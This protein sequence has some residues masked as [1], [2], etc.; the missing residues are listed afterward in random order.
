MRP[1]DN[2]VNGN[3]VDPAVVGLYNMAMA[4]ET[5]TEVT[6]DPNSG[7]VLEQGI[8]KDDWT[9]N[10][11]LSGMDWSLE[12]LSHPTLH[13]VTYQGCRPG[14]ISER[15]AKM[16][17]GRIDLDQVREETPGRLAT[18]ER[19][20]MELKSYWEYTDTSEQI[21]SPT[22]APRD[23]G[24]GT[25]DS[26]E[27]GQAGGHDGYVVQPILSDSGFR[28]D[29]FDAANVG[30]G[31]IATLKGT[32]NEQVPVVLHSAWMP[33]LSGLVDA[34]RLRFADELSDEAMASVPE[35]LHSSIREVAEECD[36][37]L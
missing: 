22:F 34:D 18:F 26:Y 9:F 5:I 20:S 35:E 28:V 11:Q 15:A 4:P 13:H 25:S 19:G 31:P 29:L 3:P 14:N 36:A 16:Y 33:Q 32:N 6:F 30:A 37:L 24:K 12:G 8:Y 10:L 1:D 27:G 7:K 23:A 2:D 21:T 17:E